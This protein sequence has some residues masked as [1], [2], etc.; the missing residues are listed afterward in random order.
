MIDAMVADRRRTI[1]WAAWVVLA[2]CVLPFVGGWGYLAVVSVS[3]G[4]LVSVPSA[5]PRMSGAGVDG[6]VLGAIAA[7]YVGVVVLIRLAFIGFGV[8]RTLGLFL[9]F[10]AA[11]LLGTVGPVVH[12]AWR[13]HRSLRA[14]GLRTDNLRLTLVLGLVFAA[15][16][17]ALTL[18]GYDLPEPVDWVPLLV[19][20]LVV[21][22]FESVFFRGFIQN[23]LTEQFGPG[24]GVAGAAVAYGLYHVGYGMGLTE[25]GFLTG[26]GV[27]YSVAFSLT[28]NVLV[29]WPL[30]TPMGSFYANVTAGDIDLPWASILGFVD[31]AAL[32]VASFWFAGRAHR[33]RLAAAAATGTDRHARA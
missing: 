17:F 28:R 25:I 1:A 10:G 5:R 8:D 11:L 20:A 3:A 16:Q 29:L 14:V 15:V 2:L 32:M 9:S 26:L 4:V 31:V 30:L 19:M 18:W 23:R 21:G 24:T 33:R 12:T 22:M 27:V 6:S 13:Q 7:L